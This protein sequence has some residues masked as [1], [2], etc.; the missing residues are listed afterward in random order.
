ME[1]VIVSTGKMAGAM[2]VLTARSSPNSSRAM[3]SPDAGSRVL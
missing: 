2:M 1:A 3:K